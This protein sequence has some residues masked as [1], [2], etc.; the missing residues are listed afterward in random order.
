MKDIHSHLLYGIDDG[1]RSIDESIE[2]LKEMKLHG[3]DELVF[4]PHYVEGSNYNCNNKSKNKLFDELKKRVKEENIDIKLYLGNEVFITT[5]FIK[6]LNNNEIQTINNSKYLLFEFPLRQVYKNTSEIVS[7]LTSN[8]YIPILAHPERYPIFQRHPDMLEEYLR[9]G[10]LMQC[11]L[12]S[13]FNVY[14]NKAKT[15]MKYFLKKKWITFLGSDTHHKVQFDSKKLEKKL[16]R[17]TKDKEYVDD[18]LNNNFDKV[19]NDEYI[20]MIR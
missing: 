17:I 14:G 9:K 19:I 3:I 15:T 10:I 13:L 1:S 4:T 8:G 2:L 12:T 16:L 20:P 5:K 6:L 11:N 18:L 7:D